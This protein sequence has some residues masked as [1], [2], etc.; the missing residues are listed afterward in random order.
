MRLE[1][2]DLWAGYGKTEV[3]RGV[4]LRVEDGE[5]VAIIGPNGA[6]KSTV[7]RALYGQADVRRGD[8]L[9]DGGSI[10]DAPPHTLVARGIA[11]VPQGRS[12][13]PSLTR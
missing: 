3:L 11:C 6:G 9:L 8:V 10:R 4:S 5:I 13:F 12:V 7:L 2:R 1:V